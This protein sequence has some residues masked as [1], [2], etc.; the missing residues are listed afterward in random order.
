MP[1]TIDYGAVL[2]DAAGEP[3]A[4]PAQTAGPVAG[5][6]PLQRSAWEIW[7]PSIASCRLSAVSG[8]GCRMKDETVLPPGVVKGCA[9]RPAA[10]ATLGS[11]RP[12]CRVRVAMSPPAHSAR[13]AAPAALPSSLAFFQMSTYCL[14]W[15]RLL[16]LA[17]SPSWPDR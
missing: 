12:S 8:V 4:A 2:P 1:S 7:L 17:G 5:S 16:R 6:T 3:G 15:A 13:A 9:V 11:I 14:P 10:G